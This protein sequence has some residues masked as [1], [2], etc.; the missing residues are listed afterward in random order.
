MTARWYVAK[1]RPWRSAVAYASLA[2]VIS[3]RGP[4][5]RPTPAATT[6]RV[7]L[8]PRRD[9]VCAA[10]LPPA[11]HPRLRRPHAF[12]AHAAAGLDHEAVVE[13]PTAHIGWGP[14]QTWFLR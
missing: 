9:H 11:E 5:A 7:P 10:P 4:Y 1:R 3:A 2:R 6:D 13:A 8:R 12:E 14:T